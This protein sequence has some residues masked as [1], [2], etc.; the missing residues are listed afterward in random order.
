VLAQFQE[1]P[2]P[3]ELGSAPTYCTLATRFAVRDRP[4]SLL[5]SRV[6]MEVRAGCPTGSRYSELLSEALR[7]HLYARYRRVRCRTD[8]RE[9]ALPSALRRQIAA[10]VAENLAGDLT[11]AALVSSVHLSPYHFA[12]LLKQTFGMTPHQYVTP[13]RVARAPAPRSGSTFD[14]RGLR[15]PSGSQTRAMAAI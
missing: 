10:F 5:L 1:E 9:P 13:A 3:S 7:S 8:R 14:R 6:A 2:K 12:R 15:R 4:L 11:L